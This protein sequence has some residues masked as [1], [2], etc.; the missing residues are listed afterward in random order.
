MSLN[1]IMSSGVSGMLSHQQALTVTSNNISNVQTEGYARKVV[2]YSAVVLNGIGAGVEVA[3]IR[4]VTD[5]FIMRELRLADASTE[6]YR[7]MSEMHSKLQSLLGDPA[8]NG[9]L[10]GKLDSLHTAFSSLTID[11]TVSVSR[12][13]AI[14]EINNF[15]IEAN[16]LL[17]N[18]QALRK[19]ADRHLSEEIQVVNDAI[20]RIDTLN[21]EIIS[22]TINQQPTGELEDQRDQ[23]LTEISKIMDIKTYKQSNGGIAVTTSNG[24]QLLDYEPRQLVYS[25]AATVTSETTFSQITVNV[26]DRYNKVIAPTG[27]PLNP[28]LSGG[29]LRGWLNM[30]DTDLPNLADQIGTLSGA[31]AEQYNAIHNANMSVPPLASMTGHNSGLAGTEDHGF[32]GQAT[33]Y[34]F[35]G[36]NDVVAS[37]T[38]DFD[39]P[40]YTSVDDVLTAVN[41]ALGAGTMTL[42]NGVMSMT[43]Q[44]GA[45]GVGIAQDDTLPSDRAGRGF[46]HYFGLNDLIESSAPTSFNTGLTSASPHGFT[47]VTSFTY[48]DADG[49]NFASFD[50]DFDAI[51]GTM[52][53]VVNE[54]N[55][56]LS[57][58]ATASLD[59]DGAIVVAKAGGFDSYKLNIT[60]DTSDRGGTGLRFPD[61]FGL[62][63]AY[64]SDM[65]VGL[66]VREDIAEDPMLMALARVEVGGS[67]ALNLA[68]NRGALAFEDIKSATTVFRTVGGL[69]GSNVTLSEYASQVL[70][71]SGLDAAR[72]QRL[73]EDRGALGEALLSKHME[74]A[75]VNIDEE[76]ANLIVYQNAYNASAR[77]ITTARDMYDTLLGIV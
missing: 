47:G 25:P 45:T 75:G 73:N 36:N 6:Q 29:S 41:G 49:R 26:Y 66:A 37:F 62:G 35:D 12:T 51:G 54:L 64:P 40:A 68:D 21:E 23:A 50:V 74:S 65:G 22:A 19:E 7:V 70:A 33:F 71:K 18:V 61:M 27:L 13:A 60:N 44:G 76:M 5:E 55:S 42:T 9:S 15:G 77:V 34:S 58:A 11:P 48:N 72:S 57:P 14:A 1:A 10:T 20:L 17:D 56:N 38:V 30:R 43:A 53:D 32:T 28:E 8:E 24:L 46:S 3:D 31:V 4:R 59:A 69:T 67:P 63:L 39:N 52:A 16:R 2:D